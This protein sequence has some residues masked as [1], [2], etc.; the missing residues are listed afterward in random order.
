MDMKFGTW[1]L[2]GLNTAG[3]LKTVARE[4]AKNNLDLVA[5]QEV[6]RVEGGSQSADVY[7]FYMEII[8]LIISLRQGL[9]NTWESHEQL[10]G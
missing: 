9:M 4:I 3:S 7:T 2:S 8:M 10:R 5:V 6:R 1:N